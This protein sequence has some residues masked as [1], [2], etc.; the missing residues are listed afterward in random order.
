MCGRDAPSDSRI[1]RPRIKI[2]SIVKHDTDSL[3]YSRVR[4]DL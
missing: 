4:G 3:G 2:A 1:G